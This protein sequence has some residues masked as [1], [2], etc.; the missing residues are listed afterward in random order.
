MSRLSPTTEATNT[1]E[2]QFTHVTDRISFE[3]GVLWQFEGGIGGAG[4]RP[5][6]LASDIVLENGR[7]LDSAVIKWGYVSGKSYNQ[8]L[9]GI[10]ISHEHDRTIQSKKTKPERGCKVCV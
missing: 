9:Y 7:F 10:S 6:V 5:A 1:K 3:D 8:W 2:G 4:N